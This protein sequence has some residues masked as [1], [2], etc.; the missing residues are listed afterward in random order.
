MLRQLSLLEQQA[1]AWSGGEPRL[2]VR[3]S[4]RA[5]RL[6]LKVVPPSRLE[7]VVPGRTPIRTIQ[8]FLDAH[9][10]WIRRAIDELKA[11]YPAERRALPRSVLLRAID[12]RWHVDVARVAGGRA[13]LLERGDRLELCVSERADD[14]AFELLRQ[15]LLR[16]GRARLKPWLAAEAARLGVRPRRVA[17]RTQ[18]TRWGSCSQ[19][20]NVNLNAALLLLPADQVRYLLVHELCHLRHL[21]HSPRYW[22]LVERYEPDFRALDRALA[23]AWADLP[24]W[25]LPR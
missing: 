15:W 9:S 16:Q 22:Q 23:T 19:A 13:S 2:V 11:R 1:P 17:V 5:R 21:D 24:V 3:Q 25:A 18:R 14:T 8:T 4:R 7:L 20:G 6:T 10:A 12:R